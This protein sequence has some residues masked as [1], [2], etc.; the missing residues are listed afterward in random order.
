VKMM[1]LASFPST[2][3]DGEEDEAHRRGVVLNK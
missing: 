3:I 2:I 1:L